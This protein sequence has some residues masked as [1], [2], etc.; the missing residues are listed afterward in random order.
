MGLG[1]TNIAVRD[2]LNLK[3]G[4]I[5]VLDNDS[6]NTLVAQAEGIPLYEG[7]VG[8]YRNKKVFKVDHPIINQI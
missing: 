5:I 1:N 7:Y 3:T 8:R 6:N 2:F 4:D